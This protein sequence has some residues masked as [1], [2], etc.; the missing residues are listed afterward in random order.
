MAM[1]FPRGSEWRKWDLHVH[2]PGTK[3]T[4]G[5]AKKGGT[6][7]WEQ[8]CQ[9]IHDS[10]VAAVGITD[11]FSLDT[12]FEFK[13]H[14]V[15]LYSD[16]QTKIFFP[17]LELRLPESLNLAGQSVNIHVLFRPDLSEADAHR[18][19]ISL[20]TETTTGKSKK[21]VVCSDLATKADY[22][23][24]TVSR[25]SIEDALTRT[26]GRGEPIEN[27]ALIIASAKG[28]GIRSGGKSSKKRKAQLVDEIDKLSHGFFAGP[29]SRDHF[30]NVGRL[31]A[32]EEVAPKPVF[33]GCDAH[34]FD[35]LRARLG[36]HD[37]TSTPH[38]HTTWVK[39]DLT[40]EGLLQTLV[41]PAHRIAMQSAQPDTKQPYQYISKVKF[42]GTDVFP[43][44]VVFNPN[45]NS[46]IGSRSSGKS[47]LL[48]FTA[49]AV[50]PD[51]TVQQQINASGMNRKDIGPAAG[52]SWADVADIG[53]EV[54]WGSTGAS[55]G[56]VI[57]IPQNSLYLL[58]EQP[59]R[60][61]EKIAP[62]LFRH[63]P[64]FAATH[65]QEIAA[66]SAAND[67]IRASV[68]GWFSIAEALDVLEGEIRDL[69]DKNAVEQARDGL[70]TRVKD[71]KKKSQLTDEEIAT[72][73]A[74]TAELDVKELRLEE[75]DDD[76][77][78]LAQ[79]ATSDG[80]GATA[81]LGQVQVAVS[82]RPSPDSLPD[83]LGEAVE[84]LR[85]AA[86]S[87]LTSQIE[88]RLASEL[89]SA[90]DEQRRLRQEV[91]D[92]CTE[93]AA[94]IAKHAAN[95]ELD[96]VAKDLNKQVRVL[97][98]IEKKEAGRRRKRT[99]QTSQATK[100]SAALSL[101]AEALEQLQA[102]FEAEPRT[103]GD[104]LTFGLEVGTNDAAIVAQSTAFNR[105]KITPY[106]KRK[107]EEVDIAEAQN[108]PAT[109][110]AALHSGKQEL[111]RG[112]DKVAAAQG[113][114]TIT[115][116]I[117][118]TAELD[119]DRIGGFGRSTMTPGK[120]AL[121]ALTLM[122]NESQEPWPLLI[123]QPED[124]LD[125]R[126]IYDTIVPYLV[127]RKRERQ[128]IMVSH[129]ANLVIGADTEE[130][131]VA[132]RHG[133]DRPNHAGRTF[134]Y[135]TGALE[136]TQPLNARSPTVLGRYG[137]REHAC[138]ILDGGEEA[139]QKRK[140]KYKI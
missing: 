110:L 112:V 5:Y 39:A 48:A 117:R 6:R 61:T 76:L 62:S 130:L 35:E 96:V 57:Y 82:V 132:N 22:E 86:A 64:P 135:L 134:E 24:A 133:T 126:S 91:A 92:C 45:L 71:I 113:T 33:D 55:S 97:A 30:L 77:V 46:I 26:F 23:S 100:I 67:C 27:H 73:Q 10:D 8:F 121:F 40:Y 116:E 125:S 2:S 129:D 75:I 60:V 118:F 38:C 98:Q 59:E 68:A 29:N 11:Y 104:D 34:T 9:I 128:I 32:D 94:L 109:F 136:H 63:Y 14:Y 17:N 139:F 25:T 140:D 127:D 43:A 1:G 87:A 15:G 31:E 50:D 44:D 80:K 18:F 89:Q 88:I 69:G 103:L 105:V 138:E 56:K 99:D 101:R 84:K 114:L 20:E 111:N 119:N 95:V 13:K 72:Y 41:E 79:Y 37:V 66:V 12:F 107:G 19:L 54:E 3:L 123:D 106:V 42:S 65:E 90:F 74:I 70:N 16:E 122:L 108:D 93:H 58:S 83:R 7:D 28:D 53:H 52:L 21:T 4:D 85:A 102:A 78:T 51:D 81:V 36:N 124:D 115:P 131:I 49:H 47:A 120:R 137:I